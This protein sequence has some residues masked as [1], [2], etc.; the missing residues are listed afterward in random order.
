[1]L[2][3]SSEYVA[4][5]EVSKI[6]DCIRFIEDEL[7]ALGIDRR[8]TLRSILAAEDMLAELISRADAKDNLTIRISKFFSDVTITISC[9]GERLALQET[10]MGIDELKDSDLGDEADAVVRGIVM[11][12]LGTEQYVR[13]MKGS[14][15]VR[16]KVEKSKYKNLYYTFGAMVLGVIFGLIIKSLLPHNITDIVVGNVFDLISTMFLNAVKMIVA[17]L[18]FFSVSSSI[19]GFGDLKALGKTGGKVMGLYF[20]TSIIAIFVAMG[21]Y[22]LFPAGNPELANAVSDAGA[23]ITEA[24]NEAGISI[25]DTIIGIIPS[26]LLQAFISSDML[27]I[28]FIAFLLGAVASMLG[29]YS[30][31]IKKLLNAMNA[32]FSKAAGVIMLCM[33]VAVFSSMAALMISMNGRTMLSMLSWVAL[34]YAAD[35]A[36]M[37]VYAI[38][39]LILTRLNPLKFFSNYFPAIATAF[40]FS[41]SNA[42]LPVSLKSCKERLG[43][44]PRIYSFSIPLGATINMDGSCVTQVISAFFMAKVFGIEMSGAMILSLI[45]AVYLLSVGAPGVPG[46]ALVCVSLLL[47]QIGVPA[48]ALS[49]LIGLYSLVSTIQTST[50]VTGD[51]AVTLIVAKSEGLVDEQ[52]YYG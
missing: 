8:Q 46:G 7:N 11:R 10:N 47:P 41:S 3:K 4:A 40:A 16:I 6:P 20:L 1:M 43:I 34:I 30:E 48:E 38:M 18:V 15:I 39:I 52:V 24:A 51:A 50:N 5:A 14:N 37:A 23:S 28:I 26:N 29:E 27:Q 2:N 45:L 44:S 32:L 35:I 49:L 12:T 25:K 21:I 33:P 42:T 22:M 19:A 17:P 31:Y 36:M 13:Y 9:K